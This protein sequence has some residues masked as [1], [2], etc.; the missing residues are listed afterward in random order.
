[1]LPA[2]HDS[3]AEIINKWKMLVDET[4]SAELDVWPDL[5]KLSADVISRAAFGSN[6]E[7]GQMIFELIIEETDL[8][9]QTMHSVYI[10]GFRSV[11]DQGFNLSTVGK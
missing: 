2:F 5:A 8:I 10:P 7:E 9:L 3:C 4:G 6:Y 11:A 1:M